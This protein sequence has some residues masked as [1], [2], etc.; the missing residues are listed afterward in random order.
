MKVIQTWFLILF[1]FS[2]SCINQKKDDNN[3][4]ALSKNHHL[5]DSTSGADSTNP[6]SNKRDLSE[7]IE[8]SNAKDIADRTKTNKKSSPVK[9]NIV[10]K[11]I[12]VKPVIYSQTSSTVIFDNYFV[13]IEPYGDNIFSIFKLPDCKYIGGF[14]KKGRGPKEFPY[15]DAYSAVGYENG[16]LMYD[17]Q[18]GFLFIN[19]TKFESENE[20]TIE[21]Q[22]KMPGE[23][24]PL[25]D[26]LLLNDSIIIGSNINFSRVDGY[27][28][29]SKYKHVKFN[30]NSKDLSYFG[31]YP[32]E[33][34][35]ERKELFPSIYSS[36]SIVKPDKTKFATFFIQVKMFRIYSSDGTIEKE[37]FLKK[38]K[39]FFEGQWIRKNAIK[40]Y[41]CV[42]ATNEY[43]YALC[44][45]EHSH[46]LSKSKPTLEIW[47]WKGNPIAFLKLDQSICSFDVTD[48]NSK[49]Y[50]TSFNDM[51][52]IFS[53]KIKNYIKK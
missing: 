14:G 44:Q 41:T 32:K 39:D 18:K 30:N 22:I 42:R 23:L 53:Y 9:E 46:D 40:Y 13:D 25:N 52:K 34:S 20:F 11:P 7:N 35:N 31:P 19:L 2:I 47:D 50:A 36:N 15:P 8:P 48:D 6:E 38:Q 33:Y 49:V 16:V 43:L 17:I 51:D 27:K 4:E 12:K 45:N 21:K 26:P 24:T 3:N 5:K 29:K 1:I 28:E 10:S 37:I